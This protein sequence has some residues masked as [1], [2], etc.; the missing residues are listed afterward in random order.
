M[1]KNMIRFFVL[2]LIVINILSCTKD[3]GPVE[4][5]IVMTTVSFTDDVQPI[6]TNKCVSC[7]NTANNQ[8]YGYLDLSDGN[9]YSN[10]VS[11]V[12]NGYAP[13]KRVTPNDSE[14]SVLWQKINNSLLYGSNMP[15]TGS[16]TSVEIETIKVW[17]DEGALNN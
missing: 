4:P 12:S 13:N 8:F 16:L 7:H 11:V 9:A 6:F 14:H 17:I 3:Q 15:L 2:I 5:E 10:L 1:I